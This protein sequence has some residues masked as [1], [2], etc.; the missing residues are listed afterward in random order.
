MSFSL[1]IYIKIQLLGTV[2][3]LCFIT[4]LT[5]IKDKF[6]GIVR[7]KGGLGIGSTSIK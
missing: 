1:C 4:K 5:H 3:L 7:F 6:C 2:Y